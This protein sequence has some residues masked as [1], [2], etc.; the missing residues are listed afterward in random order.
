MIFLF[1]SFIIIHKTTNKQTRG[2]ERLMDEW[3]KAWFVWL[4]LLVTVNFYLKKQG[5]KEF[6]SINHNS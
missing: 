6:H 3:N 5:A 4:F 1:I 2:M